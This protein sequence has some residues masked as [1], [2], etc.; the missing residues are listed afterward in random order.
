MSTALPCPD[1]AADATGGETEHDPTCPLARAVDA[2]TDADQLWFEQHPG[3]DCYWREIQPAEAADIRVWQA[4][5]GQPVPDAARFAG[6]VRVTQL[7]PGLRAR[8]FS[9]V[10]FLLLPCGDRA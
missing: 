7:A 9:G 6:R 1:C 5:I 3:T 10:Y 8:D 2:V 4:E